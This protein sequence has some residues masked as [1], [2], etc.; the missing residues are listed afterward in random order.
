MP[1]YRHTQTGYVTL[2]LLVT[3]LGAM[4][5]RF[6]AGGYAL[7]EVLILLLVALSALVFSRQTVE[8]AGEAVRVLVGPGWIHRTIPLPEIESARAI[9]VPWYV[10]WG[11]RWRGYW[12]YNV[13]GRNAVLLRLRGGGVFGVGTDDPEA[14][15]AALHRAGVP[16]G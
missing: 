3:G 6:S 4:L 15:L 13:S 11:V 7:G 2:I 14:L 12:L 8:I 16:I 10:G 9:R 5:W 1:S